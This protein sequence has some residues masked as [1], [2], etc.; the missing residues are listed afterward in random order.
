MSLDKIKF[1]SFINEF[2]KIISQNL[3]NK[4]ISDFDKKFTNI[5]D[6]DMLRWNFIKNI[7]TYFDIGKENNEIH[8]FIY[9]LIGAL[10]IV[11]MDCK[12]AYPNI[13]V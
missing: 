9:N 1:Q 11:S 2:K 3:K 4:K 12:Q 10:A 13:H 8:M 5:N 6:F 7:N